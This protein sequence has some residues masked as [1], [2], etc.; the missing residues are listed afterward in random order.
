MVE[1]QHPRM[2]QLEFKKTKGWGGKRR[3]AGR[4]NRT[5]M[6]NHMKREEVAAKYP[7]HITMRI[8]KGAISLR[9]P[10]MTKAFKAGLSKAKNAGLGVVHYAVESNHVH[11]FAESDSNES[12][13]SGMSSFGSSFGKAIRKA[14]GGKGSVFQGRYHL[15][16]LKS[17]R[18]T[19][20]ALAYVL[21][22]HSK[23][24]GSIPYPDDHS[25]AC[26]FSD[27]KSLLGGRYRVLPAE[28]PPEFLSAAQS[29]LGRKG[30]RK[31]PA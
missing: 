6:V 4:K 1:R 12:L 2:K 16:V 17:P 24:E 21:L 11:L 27:W 18:Q 20:N 15:R 28:E 13:R 26:Y 31:A 23:H 30:W 22:N 9:G 5:G 14:T 10:K 19:K 29:W 3:G 7:M 25:S 8:K